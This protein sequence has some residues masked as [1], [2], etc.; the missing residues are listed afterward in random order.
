MR[1]AIC[2]TFQRGVATCVGWAH[3]RLSVVHVPYLSGVERRSMDVE[4]DES[5]DVELV[6]GDD[7]DDVNLDIDIVRRDGGEWR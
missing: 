5:C 4:D 7:D 2:V 1:G 6:E 3:D